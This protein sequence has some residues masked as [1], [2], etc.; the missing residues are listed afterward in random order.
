[1]NGAAARNDEI[2]QVDTKNALFN[3]D[4]EQEVFVTHL[5]RYENGDPRIACKLNKALY[6]LKTVAK[7]ML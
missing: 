5:P 4:L 3:G 6:G 1:M 2:H 7:G